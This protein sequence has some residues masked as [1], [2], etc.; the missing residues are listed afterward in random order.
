MEKWIKKRWIQS[1]VYFF[2][3]DIDYI[4]IIQ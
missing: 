1:G 2:Y 3:N 4:T